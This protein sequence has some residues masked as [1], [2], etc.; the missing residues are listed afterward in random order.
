MWDGSW[1]F[2]IQKA[3]VTRIGHREYSLDWHI[4]CPKDRLE[5]DAFTT[6]LCYSYVSLLS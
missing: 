2:Y 6:S 1:F 3:M 5:V 4:E